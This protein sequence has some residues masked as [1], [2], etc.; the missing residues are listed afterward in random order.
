MKTIP[1][2]KKIV[3]ETIFGHKKCLGRHQFLV[4]KKILVGKKNM[5]KKIFR[6]T[7]IFFRLFFIPKKE[8]LG[9]NVGISK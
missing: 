5:V 6:S 7:K 4:E 1:G 3:V 9:P 2:T 8:R